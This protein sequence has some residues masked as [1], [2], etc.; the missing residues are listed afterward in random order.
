[1]HL[2]LANQRYA[3]QQCGRCC[4]AFRPALTPL[5]VEAIAKLP[6]RGGPPT[7]DFY[8][9][10]QGRPLLRKEADGRC[11]Y[12]DGDNRCRMHAAF[13]PKCKALSC[14][15]YPF[16]LLATF[17]GEVSVAA[18]YDCPAVSAGQGEKLT[19]MRG[20][21]EELAADPQLHLGHG[22]SE[23]ELDG[24]SREAVEAIAAAC[25][26][27]VSMPS[28]GAP[29]MERLAVALEK[30]G[31][32]FVNDIPTLKEVL[33]SM[34]AKALRQ[35]QEAPEPLGATWPQR[36]A[37]RKELVYYLR[38]DE[39][40]EDFGL[41]TRL[42]L[43]SAT[44]S[45]YF[46]GGTA[47]AFSA[48][49]PAIPLRQARLFDERRWPAPPSAAMAPY[50]IFVRTRL[51]SLQFFGRAYHGEP[52]FKGLL[53]LAATWRIATLLARLHAAENN[54]QVVGIQDVIYARDVVD[55]CFGRRLRKP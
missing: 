4:R 44:A 30:L 1:M 6:W 19:A 55:H 23:R 42:R 14:R 11:V 34:Q 10:F 22:F 52:F 29:A 48:E 5:E 45:V 31:R 36:T 26:E 3:C 33:P 47:R 16:E 18:R 12:L 38:R 40:L 17:P 53:A 28:G 49:H 50:H 54:M 39:S 20:E 8:T 32:A 15:A 27:A 21:L 9:V 25:A 37:L 24:L 43:A 41:R 35:A 7:R 46:G 13:G 2:R 51:E